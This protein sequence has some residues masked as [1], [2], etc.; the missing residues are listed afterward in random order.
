MPRH[1]ERKVLP[2]TPEQMF[3]LIADVERYPEFL[4]WCIG[5]RVISR[6]ESAMLADLIIG[7]KV[8]RERFTSRVHL[9]RPGHIH[10]S[11]IRGPLKYLRNDWRFSPCQENG[12]IV[13]FFV[14]FEFKNRLFEK[15]VGALFSE[16]T[17]RMI[18]AFE[19]RA[20]SLY[21]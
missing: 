11:Y 1:R 12:C 5:A 13:D 6:S 14:D 3:D 19:A 9:E 2:Y 15:L 20:L 16:A 4:P 8:F 17:R 7:F 18:D 10:V 21:G